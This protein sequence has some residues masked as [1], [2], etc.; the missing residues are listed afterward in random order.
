MRNCWIASAILAAVVAGALAAPPHSPPPAL[1]VVPGGGG[2][3]G[4]SSDEEG[5]VPSLPVEW[6]AMAC[7]LHFAGISFGGLRSACEKKH[8][9]QDLRS[10]CCPVLA[11]WLFAAQAETT[12]RAI[13]AAAATSSSS[14][15]SPSPQVEMPVPPDDSA[16]CAASLQQGFHSRGID[17]P[18]LNASCD[19]SLCYCGIRLRQMASL[20]CPVGYFHKNRSALLPSHAPFLRHLQSNCSDPSLHGCSS[21]IAALDNSVVWIGQ[22]V[23]ANPKASSSGATP[24]TLDC[25]L[26]GLMWLLSDNR[27]R[28]IPTVSAVLR[29]LL[30]STD[31]DDQDASAGDGEVP[32]A[33]SPGACRSDQAQLPLASD[34]PGPEDSA[35]LLAHSPL[36][37]SFH[38]AF[39]FVFFLKL[40]LS[41]W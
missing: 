21:C 34:S 30:Y 7:D 27:T 14:S 6:Q 16:V 1:P 15:S 4:S 28:F 31:S 20:N 2:S 5:T 25:R 39:F 9:S 10:R 3:N 12:M 35:A 33:A 17:L 26:M 37:L 23:A 32:A 40:G 29:A 41:V 13:A 19:M 24:S 36:T 38:R 11:S 18:L 8:H 22:K